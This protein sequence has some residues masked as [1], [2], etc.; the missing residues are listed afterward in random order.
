MLYVA[1]FAATLAAFIGGFF[2]VRRIRRAPPL[3]LASGWNVIHKR[4]STWL[5]LG[6]AALL[7]DPAA[8]AHAIDAAWTALPGDLRGGLPPGAVQAVGWA[9]VALKFLAMVVRQPGLKDEA[10]AAQPLT[11]SLVDGG[12]Q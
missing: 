9:L 7:T 2:F 11:G 6:G 10:A 5:T 12:S 3:W 4:W 1:T 8:I